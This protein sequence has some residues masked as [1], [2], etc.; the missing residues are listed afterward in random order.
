MHTP[1]TKRARQNQNK[2]RPVSKPDLKSL[3]KEEIK[4]SFLQAVKE[5]IRRR[6]CLGNP[7]SE[8]E[9]VTCLEFAA[10]STL[11]KMDKNKATKEL[12]KEDVVLNGLLDERK[13]HQEKA[14]NTSLSQNRSIN[15]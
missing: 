2:A 9:I 3:E 6:R 8:S 7:I 12:W 5:D 13:V 15:G 14:L 4:N 11:A 1:T 10:E